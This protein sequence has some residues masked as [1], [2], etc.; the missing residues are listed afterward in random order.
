MQIVRY[1]KA[2][3]HWNI[4][5][6]RYIKFVSRLLYCKTLIEIYASKRLEVK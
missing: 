2:A 1:M 5:V 4:Y 6:Q 3:D